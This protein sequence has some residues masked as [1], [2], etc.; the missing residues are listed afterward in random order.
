MIFYQISHIRI[1]LGDHSAGFGGDSR[2]RQ[3]C[4]AECAERSSGHDVGG[5]G[6]PREKGHHDASDDEEEGR[7]RG[8]K[9]GG[10]L[11]KVYVP[12]V[13]TVIF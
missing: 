11:R 4:T 6:E 10:T 12:I 8:R 5:K 9:R 1:S 7:G 3:R 2:A 13:P